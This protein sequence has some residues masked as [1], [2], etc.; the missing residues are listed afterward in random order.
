MEVQQLAVSCQH[1][2]LLLTDGQAF[3]CNTS[4]YQAATSDTDTR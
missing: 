1:A 2:L 3:C 4:D